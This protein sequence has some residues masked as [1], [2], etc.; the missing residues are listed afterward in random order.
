MQKREVVL[1][2]III[3]GNPKGKRYIKKI[4]E[5]IQIHTADGTFLYDDLIG[6]LYGSLLYARNGT[7][8]TLEKA[9]LCDVL[10]ALKRKTQ[11]IYPK[12]IAYICMRLGIGRNTRVIEAGTGS[13]GLTT[14]FSYLTSGSGHVYTYEA[15]EEFYSLAK[16]NLSW[17]NL[18]DNVTQYRRD[19][20]EG[21][22]ETDVDAL[23]LDVREP[24]LYLDK[25][26]Q[27][28][29]PSAMCAFLLPTTNQ[30]SMLLEAM[31][32]FPFINIEVEEVLI[33][34]WKAIPDRLR[35]FDRMVAHTSFL[36]F[37]RHHN[38]KDIFEKAKTKGTREYKQHLAR[39]SRMEQKE[40]E[41]EERREYKEHHPEEARKKQ[42][43][44]E[45]EIKICTMMNTID[46]IL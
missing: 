46:P 13:G 16:E 8:Y 14:A 9:S 39:V 36:V 21:F 17:A 32:T 20:I 41:R 23:F 11:I 12:D 28:L 19:I 31:E 27:A 15:R 42:E 7:P 25:V 18:G 37:A 40:E 4:V 10:Y 34:K 35:P 3:L 38:D 45:Q 33:R 6:S 44:K 5:G 2:D 22:D 1:N 29:L 24:W 43:I 26:I 30:V